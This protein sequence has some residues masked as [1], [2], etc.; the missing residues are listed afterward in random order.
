[1][2]TIKANYSK[3]TG[4]L[5]SY[6]V[7]I[8][9]GYDE[10]GTQIRKSITI[11]R[12]EGM[13]PAKEK[14]EVQRIADQLEKDAIE[15]YNS[16]RTVTAEEKAN[17]TFCQFVDKVWMPLHVYDG[18]HTPSGITHFK[19]TSD[20]LK[21]YFKD[22]KLCDIDRAVILSYIKF[23]RTKARTAPKTKGDKG[24]PLSAYTIYHYFNTLRNIMNFAELV[25]Y[26]DVNPI[27]KL[28]K[29][30]IPSKVKPELEAGED[31]LTPEQA[32]DFLKAINEAQIEHRTMIATLI[33]TGVRR[34]ELCGLQWGDIDEVNRTITVQRNVTR[35]ASS[36]EKI[37]I[38]ETK[39]KSTRVIP[40][41]DELYRILMEWKSEQ[42][43]RYGAKL[44]K[45]AFIFGKAE[46]PYKPI[47]PTVPTTVL[48]RLEDRYNLPRVSPHDL[49]HTF[50]TMAARAGGLKAAQTLLGH[51]DIATTGNF[52][53]GVSNDEKQTVV[54]DIEKLMKKA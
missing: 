28:R 15:E 5:I 3:T 23:L 48:Y 52:Y 13:T 32:A 41:G 19:Y 35:D 11:K 33:Y 22:V 18:T 17:I 36:E 42:K 49:R 29:S 20:A 47:Y 24:Q 53:L 46:D 39:T 14:K 31:F 26:I 2:A 30:D 7:R 44:M 45:S 6:R 4:E 37:H 50:G 43:S 25:D 9:I 1:M 40:I 8:L 34:G 16:N 21:T 12:P 10:T 54:N 38:G 51:S 27:R